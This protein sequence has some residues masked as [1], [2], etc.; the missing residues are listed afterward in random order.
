MTVRN[1]LRS[2]ACLYEVEPGVFENSDNYLALTLET[3][4]PNQNM[5]MLPLFAGSMAFVFAFIPFKSGYGQ[6][7]NSKGPG[8]EEAAAVEQANTQIDAVYKQLMNKLD[9]EGQKSLREAQRSWIKWRDNEA[10]LIARLGGAVGG[11][12]LRVDSLTAQAKLIR[13]RTE[14]LREYLQHAGGN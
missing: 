12:A 4:I 6:D 11:S 5:K 7:P 2:P 10:P 1:C 8:T 9:A 3:N 14:V 13:Q